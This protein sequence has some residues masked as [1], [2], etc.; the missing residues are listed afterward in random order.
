[1]IAASIH[2]DHILTEDSDKAREL[3][4]KSQFGTIHHG[5]VSLTFIEALY[6]VEHK[7]IHIKNKRGEVIP[8][9]KLLKRARRQEKKVW[10]KYV[11]FRDLRK[12]GYIV[13]T[14]LKFG[15][16]YRVYPRGV[17]PGEDHAKWIIF[18][19][20][21]NESLTWYEFASKNR[22]AHSTKKNLLIG[23]VDE[24]NNITYYQIEWIKP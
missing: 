9:E 16:E 17:K 3:F 10:I 24:E 11:I 8:F 18:P 14:G 4:A 21:A 6:L 13:K 7:K 23:I 12:R 1:M 19:V 20:A 5:Q 2:E 22:V 15:A